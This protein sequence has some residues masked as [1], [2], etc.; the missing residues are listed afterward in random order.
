M[1]THG[2]AWGMQARLVEQA[3]ITTVETRNR[4]TQAE[5]SVVESRRNLREIQVG[6]RATSY[7]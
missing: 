2:S 6:P 4:L 1:S 3:T 7:E 5:R